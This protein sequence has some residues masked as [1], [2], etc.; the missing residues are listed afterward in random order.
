MSLL[1][2]IMFFCVFPTAVLTGIFIL[3]DYAPLAIHVLFIGIFLIF[4]VIAHRAAPSIMAKAVR[5][6]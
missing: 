5:K 3:A 6:W 2:K 4:V 1:R